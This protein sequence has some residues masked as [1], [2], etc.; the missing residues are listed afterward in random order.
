M[1]G[2]TGVAGITGTVPDRAG[3]RAVRGPGLGAVAGVVGAALAGGG[4]LRA[5]A[6]TAARPERR[7][8]LL[9]VIRLPAHV[10]D[11]AAGLIVRIEKQGVGARP[12]VGSGGRI[13]RQLAALRV[14]QRDSLEELLGFVELLGLDRALALDLTPALPQHAHEHA[15]VRPDVEEAVAALQ[16]VDGLRV[17]EPTARERRRIGHE[18]VAKLGGA[19]HERG[20]RL[21]RLGGGEMRGLRIR[22]RL[23]V[24]LQLVELGEI[25]VGQLGLD[26]VA[27]GAHTRQRAED[28]RHRELHVEIDGPEIRGL[29]R[30]P[31]LGRLRVGSLEPAD[32]GV[33]RG[34]VRAHDCFLLL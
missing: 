28:V 25:E 11:G 22:E 31:R 33:V 10:V 12:L 13:H 3:D 7:R 16:L 24:R 32:R 29:Q 30:G 14:R 26:R 19:G 6:A 21:G 5:A 27:E 15:D 20:K 34:L 17:D 9:D 1:P 2:C 18:L 4:R 8:E 23:R